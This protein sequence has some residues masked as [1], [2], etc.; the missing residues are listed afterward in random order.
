MSSDDLTPSILRS[1]RDE[2]VGL[3]ADTNARFGELH[4]RVDATNARLDRLAEGQV[5][6]ATDVAEIK[7]DVSD[8]KVDVADLKVDVSD[9]K[10]DVSDLR[11]SV[12]RLEHRFE[13]FIDTS[14]GRWRDLE[15]RVRRLEQHTG[16][17]E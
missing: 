14:G 15:G 16:L 5:R 2:I 17:S 13:G 9:L 10:V 12:S 1:I 4:E 3:R 6:I 8:L 11:G 7:A